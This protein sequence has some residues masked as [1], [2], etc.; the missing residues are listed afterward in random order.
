[1]QAQVAYSPPVGSPSV[2]RARDAGSVAS[3]DAGSAGAD[4][5]SHASS[6]SEGDSL[7]V[8]GPYW[9]EDPSPLKRRSRA[10]SESAGGAGGVYRGPARDSRAA[11]SA[12]NKAKSAEKGIAELVREGLLVEADVASVAG[13]LRRND[14]R[15]DLSKVGDYLGGSDEINRGVCNAL[16]QTLDFD[17]MQLDSALRRMISLIKLPGEAQKIDRIIEQ[18]AM[19]WSEANPGDFDHADTVQIIAFS[20]VTA[21]RGR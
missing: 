4:R 5:C 7:W 10:I 8:S 16:L 20:L 2:V 21:D 11:I 17:G 6:S 15:L 3:S 1:M 18:F 13:F 19:N 9:M 12:F 14:G